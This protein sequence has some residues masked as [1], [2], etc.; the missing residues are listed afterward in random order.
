MNLE[1]KEASSEDLTTIIAIFLA[2][3]NESYRDL[4]PQH[5]REEMTLTKARELWLP[6]VENNSERET[7]IAFVD[8]VPVGV[9]RFGRSIDDPVRGHLFSLYI[10]PKYAGKGLGNALLAQVIAKLKEQNFTE[11]SLWVFKENLSAQGL[12]NR[13]GFRATG[14]ERTDER[15]KIPEIEML[16]KEITSRT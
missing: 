10:H 9:A 11:I 3:W 16:N 7:F 12:Y 13:N 4:L 5:V 2:C 8:D 14:Q 1:V 15:W 6:A